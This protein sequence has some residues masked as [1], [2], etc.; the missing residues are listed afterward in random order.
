VVGGSGGGTPG[1][2]SGQIQYNNS[3]AFGGLAVP[4]AVANGGTG[5]TTY[6][7]GALVLLAE[8]TANNS[9]SL[10][11]TTRN[12]SG[13]SGAIFQSD[14]DVYGVEI[15]SVIPATN[16]QSLLLNYST[17][18][19]SSWD[20]GSNYAF[21]ELYIASTPTSGNGGSSTA[22]AIRL[23]DTVGNSSAGGVSG[24]Y[25]IYAP[26]NASVHTQ[27]I[28]S[29]SYEQGTVRAITT[30]GGTHMTTSADNAFEI[31]FASGNITSGTIR[32]YGVA[33]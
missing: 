2:T 18:G 29:V 15:V 20:T 10:A 16:A 3:G 30:I 4:L 26:L 11:F 8:L 22:T 21:A 23:A 31:T 5:T 25:Q 12:V 1:G 27:N 9:A 17:N 19:G 28:G 6:V 14:Y 32:V 24:N 7:P 13:Q 33:K